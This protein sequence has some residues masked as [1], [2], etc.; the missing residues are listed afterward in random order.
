MTPTE[1]RRV[2]EVS[3]DATD[4][5]VTHAFRRLAGKHHPDHGGDAARFNRLLEARDT[6]RTACGSGRSSPV[7]A[8]TRSQR[9]AHGLRRNLRRTVISRT[10]LRRRF[11]SRVQ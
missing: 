3:V 8:V 7:I 1:A 5:E 6:L 4:A 9:W 10:P 11:G 2:L